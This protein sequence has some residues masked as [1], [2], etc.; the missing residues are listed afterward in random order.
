MELDRY[1]RRL[2]HLLQREGRLPVTAIAERIDLS[3]NA[4]S[5]RLRRLQRDGI[6]EGYA[7]KVSPSALGRGLLV[8]V[9]VKLDRTTTDVFETFAR[10]AR[11]ADDVLEC[12]MVAGGFDYLLK[13][14]VADMDAYRRFLSASLLAL[15]GVR[16]THTYVVMEEIKGSGP[17]PV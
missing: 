9:E 11:E 2:L 3:P 4:T 12:H 17:L 8:F 5:E 6:I 14:R 16:E 7:A 15:P 1:D 10:A 13:T